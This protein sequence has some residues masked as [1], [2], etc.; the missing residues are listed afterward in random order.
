[1]KPITIWVLLLLAAGSLAGCTS[2]G[3]S[4]PSSDPEDDAFGEIEVEA[5]DKTGAIRGVVVDEAIRPVADA[6]IVVPIPDGEPLR[7]TTTENGA[8]G[9]SNVPPGTYFV[10]VARQGYFD[11][12]QSVDVQAGLADPVPLKILLQVN[13]ATAP[14]HQELTFS[15]FIEC[16][17][18]LIALCAVPNGDLQGDLTNDRFIQ[19]FALDAPP[20]WLQSEMVWDSTQTISDRL[21]LW[22]S[23]GD[24]E[25][26]FSG[27][28]PDPHTTGPSPLL[29]V[30]NGSQAAEV[31][32]G[33]PNQLVL[34]IFSGDIDG[35]SAPDAISNCYGAPG[36][37][38]FANGPGFALQ[39]EFTVFTHAFFN[40]EPPAEWRFTEGPVPAP[41]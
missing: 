40:Y 7:T 37:I 20:Q 14:Y 36:V 31:S 29:L 33:D 30:H 35:T 19:N 15:G 5:T 17:T 28:L 16:S 10:K 22:H 27:S 25:G 2:D 6:S 1:M 39:Q 9:F 41:A 11:A 3:P 24:E 26:S 38:C 21:W 13:A 18:T 23:Y 8:F 32:L 12:Q 4:T 34:R